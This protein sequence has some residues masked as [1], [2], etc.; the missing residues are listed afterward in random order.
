LEDAASAV[1]APTDAFERLA[2]LRNKHRR[3]RRVATGLLAVVVAAAGSSLAYI[4]FRGQPERPGPASARNADPRILWPLPGRATSGCCSTPR[5]AV[6]SFARTE[7][8]WTRILVAERRDLSDGPNGRVFTVLPCSRGEFCPEF[9]YTIVVARIDRADEQSSWSVIE[10]GTRTLSISVLPGAPLSASL[11]KVPVRGTEGTRLIAGVALP[12]SSGV[13]A[14]Y[15]HAAVHGGG[16]EVGG[17]RKI[18]VCGGRTV[19]LPETG[20][21]FLCAQCHARPRG[22][23]PSDIFS[24]LRTLSRPGSPP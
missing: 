18:N 15:D 5:A 24:L 8:R 19:T 10:V 7:L 11:S 9:A 13:C 17:V 20:Y 3:N 14:A 21:V 2:A 12:G 16:V 4:A 23:T 1:Q 6:R 22:G